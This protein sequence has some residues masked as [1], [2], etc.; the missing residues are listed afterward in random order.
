MKKTLLTL[1]LFGVL[2]LFAQG[3]RYQLTITNLTSGQVLTPILVASH[4]KGVKLFTPGGGA[5]VELEMLAEGGSTAAMMALLD[6]MPEVG[7]VTD[8]GGARSVTVYA[9]AWDAGTEPNDESCTSIPGPPG[10]CGGEGFNPDR[11][12][13][14]GFIH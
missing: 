14:E 3:P 8:T 9:S 7:D 4:E 2:P 1:A 5:P 6:A 13:A 11:M 12:G 10:V